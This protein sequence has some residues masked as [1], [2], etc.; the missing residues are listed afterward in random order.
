MRIFYSLWILIPFLF[1]GCTGK[2]EFYEEKGSIFH[3]FYQIK[4]QSP[5]YMT[6]KIDKELQDFSLSLNPFNPNSIIAKINR[7]EEVEVDQLFIDVFNKAQ[8]I[9]E[10]TGG[11]FDA[12]GA[13]LFNLWG[14]GFSKM[15][16]VTPQMVDSIKAFVGYQ[17]IRLEG[18]TIVKDDPR[19]M[20]NFSA[21]AKGYACD[22]VARMFEREG[23]TNYMVDIGGEIAISGTNQNG[24]CWRVGISKPE[25][26]PMGVNRK[27]EETVRPCKKCGVATSGDYRNYYIKDGKRY[28]HTID[29]QTGYPAGQNV[30]SATV[31]ADNCMTADGYATA[32][33]ALGSE[34][35][36]EV[37]ESIPEIDYYLIYTDE[38]GD[39]KTAYST[40][41]RPYLSN[42]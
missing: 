40:G 17:K 31:V 11:M 41:M 12:T 26:D 39:K 23:I 5:T 1:T 24:N 20:L 42:K 8:E 15:D 7:N 2:G 13:P 33:M 22:V 29:L 6:E 4:Y 16:S 27:M 30:L 38:N 19:I 14:F 35:A 3:T 10:N 34:K 36:I 28:A 18:K 32:L 37:A 9:S 21:I 25:D